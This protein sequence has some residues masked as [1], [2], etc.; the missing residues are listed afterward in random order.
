LVFNSLEY[1]YEIYLDLKIKSIKKHR[2]TP[3]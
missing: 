3:V 1:A 2:Q